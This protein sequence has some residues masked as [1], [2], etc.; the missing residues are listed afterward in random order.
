MAIFQLDMSF[1]N[2]VLSHM[3]DFRPYLR[4]AVKAKQ[5]TM[6][7]VKDDVSIVANHFPPL[8]T[9]SLKASLAVC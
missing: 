1:V 2:N 8:D 4:D 6:S 7:T 3:T 5:I 9:V